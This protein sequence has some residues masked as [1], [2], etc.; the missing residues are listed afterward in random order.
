MAA[1]PSHWTLDPSVVHLNHGSFGVVPRTVQDVQQALREEM[2]TNPDAWFRDLPDRVGLARAAVARFLRVPAEHTAL[3]VNASAGVSTV[4]GS[5]T[6]PPGGEVLLTD[7]AYGAAAMGTVRAAERA[8]ARVRTLHI[9]LEST[10]EGIAAVF[11]G[12]LSEATALVVV[13]QITSA[14]A[15]LF[16]VAEIT[17]L[18]HAVGAKV[19][20]DAA[21]AP[22]MLADPV[23]LAQGAD[24]W[25][26]NLHKWCCAPRGTAA[27]VASGPG[28]QDLW[29]LTDSWGAPDPFPQRFDIQGT[30]DLTAWLAA[31]RSL[32]FIEETYGWDL[33]RARITKLAEVAQGM[34]ADALGADLTAVRFGEAPAMRLVPLPAG[35]ATDHEAAQALQRR[36]AVGTGC[37]T[38]ITSWD[39]RGF[40]RL[41]AHLYNTV[42]DYERL[43][44][45]LPGVLRA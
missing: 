35:L 13:D 31:P 20:V 29:P 21:H 42:S 40:L 43:A 30:L 23:G 26:G 41:S 8:G 33:A 3:V 18:A 17:R 34:L 15:R 28:A 45:C 22:G 16:P 24:F 38:A 19:L 27:L 11:E 12:A 7:H 5:L 25:V 10:A 37:E 14:T 6:L 9:P 39:G 4:L 44:E 1:A 32:E 36:I 2:E